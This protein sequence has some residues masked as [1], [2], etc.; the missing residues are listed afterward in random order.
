MVEV[1]RVIVNGDDVSDGVFETGE[2]N[3]DDG[4]IDIH[5]LPTPT[6]Y[7][8]RTYIPSLGHT[9]IHTYLPLLHFFF[10]HNTHTHGGSV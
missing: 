10:L 8:R 4:E 2:V 6:T 9:Q 1:N 3:H 5:T 7:Q